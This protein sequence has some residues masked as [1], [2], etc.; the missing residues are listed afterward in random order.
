M[1]DEARRNLTKA[2]ERWENEGGA[3]QAE[4][5]RPSAQSGSAAISLFSP[6]AMIH[7]DAVVTRNGRFD[8]KEEAT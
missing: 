3:V 2:I 7:A 8:A 4:D 5:P 1:I 6:I